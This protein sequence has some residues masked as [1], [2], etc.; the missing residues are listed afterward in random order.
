MNRLIA[1][2]LSLIPLWLATAHAEDKIFEPSGNIFAPATSSANPERAAGTKKVATLT[3]E[4]KAELA[5]QQAAAS[6]AS[7]A[8][9][10]LST[11]GGGTLATLQL[12]G[13]DELL[14]WIAQHKHLKRVIADQCQL[15]PDIEA[16]AKVMMLPSYQYLW[17]DML[18][19]ATCVEK[20]AALGVEYMWSAAEHGLPAALLRLAQYYD[21]GKYVQRDRRQAVQL[22]HEAAAL[23]YTEARMEWVAMLNRGLGSP[24]DYEEAYSWLHHTVIADPGQ[25]ARASK[26]L[27]QLAARMPANI[28]S[29][30]KAYPLD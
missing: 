20:D 23:G 11:S 18:L 30:A 6:A 15:V 2:L 19:T 16:R 27:R 25:H 1:V 13:Q 21:Q 12:Y 9:S 17:G 28:V 4:Q 14:N 3:E 5:R 26:L 7:A 8:V 29:R 22:M 10:V 24:L